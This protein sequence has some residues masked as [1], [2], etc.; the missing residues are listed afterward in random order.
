MV[1]LPEELVHAIV[2]EF[3]DDTPSLKA[4]ALAGS[5]LCGASQ[6][7]LLSSFTLNQNI[8][9][10]ASILAAHALLEESPH[11]ANYITRLSIRLE[12]FVDEASIQNLQGSLQQILGKMVNVRQCILS[13][14]FHHTP[15]FIS[16]LFDFLTRQPLRELNVNLWT[17]ISAVTI[18]RFLTIAPVVSFRE[19]VI[20]QDLTALSDLS[21][22]TPKVEDL[23][24]DR[25]APQIYE[26]LAQP[27]FKSFTGTLRH[28]FVPSLS[29]VQLLVATAPMLEHLHLEDLSGTILPPPFP[30]L[31][32]CDFSFP[33]HTFNP[34]FWV[35]ISSMLG[36]S[37]LLVNLVISLEIVPRRC[38]SNAVLLTN[39]D[40]A[41]AAHPRR[42][43]VRWRLYL[44][45]CR[46]EAVRAKFLAR[47]DKGA[48][49]GTS[50]AG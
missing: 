12:W 26:L 44:K 11:I 22:H 31:R 3:C 5:M 47:F 38:T 24:I 10:E 40:T 7:L 34:Q 6:R 9:G 13:G 45:K 42:P 15:T 18:L 37:P 4:C 28:L 16:A 23:F 19:V 48:S 8:T 30:L 33:F 32:S 1:F 46:N 2:N 39:L 21:Q 20:N 17:E 35:L 29:A 49:W 41:L 25:S 36:T 50:E 14:S 43:H 27:Q